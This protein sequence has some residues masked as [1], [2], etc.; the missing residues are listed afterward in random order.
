MGSSYAVEVENSSPR[1]SLS[2]RRIRAGALALA[3]VPLACSSAPVRTDRGSEGF[4]QSSRPPEVE[5]Q[6]RGHFEELTQIQDAAVRGDVATMVARARNVAQ[7]QTPSDYPLSWQPHV[8]DVVAHA[9]ALAETTELAEATDRA[10]RLASECGQC[11]QST[12]AKPAFAS[13]EPPPAEAST[14]SAMRR[15]AWGADRMWEGLVG[16]D[17]VAWTRGAELFSTI[18]GCTLEPTDED[19][20]SNYIDELCTQVSSLG[21]LA[22][23][24]DDLEARARVYGDMLSTCSSCHAASSPG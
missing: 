2:L 12:G 14:Q 8:A 10:A 4:D 20:A 24:A 19:P 23:N 9:E 22:A 5:A 11:H 13:T 6:M 21:R 17:D 16:P 7:Q 3:M 18:P 1:D 15:H